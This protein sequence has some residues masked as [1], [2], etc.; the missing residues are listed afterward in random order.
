MLK[1][2]VK[3]T[4]AFGQ[5]NKLKMLYSDLFSEYYRQIEIRGRSTKTLK[6]YQHHN[7]YFSE[8]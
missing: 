3:G 2:D 1:G 4:R 6:T 7:R 8:F 5:T